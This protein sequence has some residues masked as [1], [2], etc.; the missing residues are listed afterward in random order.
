MSVFSGLRD[1]ERE[2]ESLTVRMSELD[3]ASPEYMQVADRYHRL[4]HEFQAHD[5]YTSEAQV[6]NVLMGLG[7]RKEDWTR[8][9]DEFSG[10]WQ[11]PNY[12]SNSQIFCFSTNP[13]TISTLKPATG[14]K[15]I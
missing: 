2:M 5:G 12:C 3:T 14:W 1:M 4:E 7:F 13:P 8:L 15:N 6:G 10:G 11:W 9:T